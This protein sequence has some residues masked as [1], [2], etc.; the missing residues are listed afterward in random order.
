MIHGRIWKGYLC[1]T[2]TPVSTVEFCF[3]LVEQK[4]NFKSASEVSKFCVN[5]HSDVYDCAIPN[6]PT[7]RV[8]R[9]CAHAVLYMLKEKLRERF[10]F[11]HL[12]RQTTGTTAN[13]GIRAT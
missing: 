4:A 12:I 1:F 11:N 9:P 6:L 7:F 2:Y 5:S 8:Y 13:P 3:S 10:K